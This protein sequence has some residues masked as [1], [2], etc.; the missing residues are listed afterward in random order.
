MTDEPI[1][2]DSRSLDADGQLTEPEITIPAWA[3]EYDA[4]LPMSEYLLIRPNI[5]DD[6]YAGTRFIIPDVAKK[7]PEWGVVEKC[8]PDVPESVVKPKDLVKFRHYNVETILI[9]REEFVLVN[10]HDLQLRQE[11]HHVLNA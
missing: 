11:G 4:P 3:V 6:T 8:G 9:N 5:Q 10:V 1:Y 7:D 2:V